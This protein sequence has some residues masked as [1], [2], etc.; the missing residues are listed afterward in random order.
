LSTG[1]R[2]AAGRILVGKPVKGW[3]AFHKATML[4][5]RSLDAGL[6]ILTVDKRLIYR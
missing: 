3:L 1:N 5:A 2:I 4:A 6:L